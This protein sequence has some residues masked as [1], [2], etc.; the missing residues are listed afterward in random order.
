MLGDKGLRPTVNEIK[1]LEDGDG[2]AAQ[3]VSGDLH[4]NDLVAS[5]GPSR[6]RVSRGDRLSVHG[7]GL[8]GGGV[9]DGG[10]QLVLAAERKAGVGHLVGDGHAA[11]V[12]GAV[13]V[14]RVVGMG[15][16]GHGTLRLVIQR[17]VV[18]GHAIAGN[19]DIGTNELIALVG[20][21]AKLLDGVGVIGK[22]TKTVVCLHHGSLGRKTEPDT[23][24]RVKLGAVNGTLG[25]KRPVVAVGVLRMSVPSGRGG[26]V[27]VFVGDDNVALAGGR[28]GHLEGDA[29]K[30]VAAV[31]CLLVEL[32]VPALHLIAHDPTGDGVHDGSIL[33]DGERVYGPV[34]EQI[35]LTNADL[36]QRVGAVR[37]GVRC[38]GGMAVLDGEGGHHVTG[39]IGHAVH[40]DRV[41]A[42][43]TNLELGAVQRRTAQRRA[44]VALKVVLVDFNASPDNI[45]GG[46]VVVNGTI[47]RNRDV[48]VVRRVEV[49]IVG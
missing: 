30:A 32:K 44:E 22:G 1:L 47:L 33:P 35:A 45:I 43:Q 8:S 14:R 3:L 11:D 40:D 36:L 15:R 23:G 31:V 16:D 49:G 21:A 26:E 29:S 48:N 39:M 19:G 46:R 18:N 6:E 2:L 34:R 28:G 12:D 13:A 7:D 4:L 20:C 41:A 38:G 17:A 24:G 37:Q 9:N 10:D 42:D 27:P 5:R 25:V